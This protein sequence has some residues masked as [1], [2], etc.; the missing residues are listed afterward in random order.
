MVRPWLHTL[1]HMTREVLRVGPPGYCAQWTMERVIGILENDLRLHSQPYANLAH[2]AMRM[3]QENS[4]IAMLPELERPAYSLTDNDID[5]GNGFAILHPIDTRMHTPS[6]PIADALWKFMRESTCEDH[7]FLE[8]PIIKVIR[9]ARAAFDD[10]ST[11]RSS[12]KED[13]KPIEHL[14]ISCMVEVSVNFIYSVFCLL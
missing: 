12:W 6:P 3:S 14:R 1:L 2:I 13:L 4:L 10:G 7:S 11:G 5:F 9:F 8:E